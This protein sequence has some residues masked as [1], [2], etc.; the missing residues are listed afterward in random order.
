MQAEGSG[1][2]CSTGSPPPLRRTLSQP[3]RLPLPPLP[4]CPPAAGPPSPH[5]QGGGLLAHTGLRM[6]TS[7]SP[8]LSGLRSAQRDREVFKGG[9]GPEA[10]NFPGNGKYKMCQYGIP[11]RE[12][13]RLGKGKRPSRPPSSPAAPPPHPCVR[14]LHV[15]K[16]PFC[17]DPSF[18]NNHKWNVCP[19][20][21]TVLTVHR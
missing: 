18:K 3:P 12:S 11:A 4:S 20:P 13:R 1:V 2:T 9:C 17:C 19:A 6:A 5:P 7:L 14:G 15:V 16:G 10:R 8:A 21:G